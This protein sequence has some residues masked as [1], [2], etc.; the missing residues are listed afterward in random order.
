MHFQ[1]ISIIIIVIIIIIIIVVFVDVVLVLFVFDCSTNAKL[2]RNDDYAC[3]NDDFLA[4]W[5]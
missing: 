1:I 4:T 3:T 5:I 2:L